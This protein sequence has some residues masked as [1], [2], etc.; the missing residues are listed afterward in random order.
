MGWTRYRPKLT[1]LS[2]TGRA[3][4]SQLRSCRTTFCFNHTKIME[5]SCQL[6]P[7]SACGQAAA[8][9]HIKLEAKW[10]FMHM[11]GSTPEIQETS[12]LNIYLRTK[13]GHSQ[14]RIIR[15]VGIHVFYDGAC[16]SMPAQPLHTKICRVADSFD[17]RL[18]ELSSDTVISITRIQDETMAPWMKCGLFMINLLTQERGKK[19]GP[20]Q[21][22]CTSMK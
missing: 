19:T 16:I 6:F 2:A 3:V 7:T 10:L 18:A 14:C 22:G 9:R 20:T 17:F 5:T 1:I 4:R 13:P 15:C 21:A 11:C 12:R 8:L